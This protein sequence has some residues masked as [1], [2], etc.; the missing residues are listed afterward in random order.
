V[1]N[2]DGVTCFATCYEYYI[3]LH[4]LEAD[5]MN[6]GLLDPCRFPLGKKNNNAEELAAIT[7]TRVPPYKYYAAFTM[8]LVSAQSYQFQFSKILT[9]LYHD[10]SLDHE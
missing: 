6:K 4:D 7:E 1:S 9:K 5:L 10:Y 2:Q 3:D 8:L